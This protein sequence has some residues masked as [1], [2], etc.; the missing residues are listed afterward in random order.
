MRQL[1]FFLISAISVPV[2]ATL[3]DLEPADAGTS[4]CQE[5]LTTHDFP[6]L[7][8]FTPAGT[9][10]YVPTDTSP[11]NE[12]WTNEEGSGGPFTSG[13][14]PGVA[15]L[16][17]D[18]Y[19]VMVN[20]GDTVTLVVKDLTDFWGMFFAPSGSTFCAPFTCRD[21]GN[22]TI[23]QNST[24][25]S[26]VTF[27]TSANE[28]LFLSLTNSA[29]QESVL[30]GKK[31]SIA[32][33]SGTACDGYFTGTYVGD[34]IVL[35]G[36]N[37]VFVSGGVT[38][39]VNATGGNLGL[40]NATTVG[41]QVQIAGN[42]TFSIDFATIGGDL[43]VSTTG[44]TPSSIVQ[45][46]CNSTV[47]GRVEINSIPSNITVSL[48]R[49]T[50]GGDVNIF[51]AD[52][53]ISSS[54]ITGK[55]YANGGSV[56]LLENTVG[57]SIEILSSTFIQLDGNTTV[58]QTN[59][60][61]NVTRVISITSNTIADSLNFLNNTAPAGFTNFNIR[62]NVIRGNLECLGNSPAPGGGAT[63]FV[64]K[65]AFDQCATL[66]G[67]PQI[68]VTSSSVSR[69]SLGNVSVSIRLGN[70]GA[71]APNTVLTLAKIGSINGQIMSTVPT[72]ITEFGPSSFTL[73]TLTFPP[74]V[75]PPGT[76]ALL[77]IGGTYFGGGFKLT[78][79]IIL[80]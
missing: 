55:V 16:R 38:G 67:T 69:D 64:I 45:R 36:Q 14:C 35:P 50:I 53:G 63:N 27:Y 66:G 17:L 28:L 29:G 4:S 48:C 61:D 54:K 71:P 10:F 2:W 33:T 52:V 15:L 51:N 8:F 5:F 31:P 26:H 78:L 25:A 57:G 24:S 40:L 49:D 37:C 75:G 65:Q 19:D 20:Q 12:F 23:F 41:G 21:I 77:T 13:F 3:V 60:H 34:L 44:P 42:T 32:P 73:N 46:V 68:L 58:G 59:V 18:L 70:Q 74:S 6:T 43:E 76:P 79:R 1:A 47:Q 9:P 39:N 11:T 30:F 72:N 80:N 56:Q 22:G 62:D 7:Q